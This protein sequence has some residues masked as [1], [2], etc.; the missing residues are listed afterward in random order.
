MGAV[1]TP[2]G[3]QV[4]VSL[5]RA[6]SIAIIDAA[7]KK[8]TRTIENVGARPWGIDVSADGTKAFT[9]NGPSGDVAVIDLASGTVEKRVQTGGSPWGLVYKQH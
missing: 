5:G 9:A 3:T 6:Q 7:T 4:L 8:L 2:D 1:L